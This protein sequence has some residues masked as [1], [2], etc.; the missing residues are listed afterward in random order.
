[1]SVAP[2]GMSVPAV[3]RWRRPSELDPTVP[4]A[5]EVALDEHRVLIRS[6]L[7]PSVRTTPGSFGDFVRAVKRGEYDDLL[8]G[9]G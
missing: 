4:D 3:P 7:G 1:M 9:V 2:T 5:V 8:D 6:S